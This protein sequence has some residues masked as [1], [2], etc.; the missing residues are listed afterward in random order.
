MTPPFFGVKA[1]TDIPCTEILDLIDKEI[2]F[3]SR[4]QFRRG[5][6]SSEWEK[7]REEVCLPIFN[8][9]AE[10]CLDKG[11]LETKALYGYFEDRKEG[12]LIFVSPS[13][14]SKTKKVQCFE[15]PRQKEEPHL[16]VADFFPDGFITMQL[17]TIGDRI[18]KEGSR[19]F[20]E[21]KYSDA[22]YLKGI[23]AEAAEAAA[24][25]TETF[26]KKELNV[27]I[28][29]GCRISFGYPAAPNLMDQKKLYMLLDGS[30]IGV[31]I[32]Q[33]Y[34]LVPE[35]STSAVVC[36]SEHSKIFRP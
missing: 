23:A 9:I 31:Q 15:F 10:M 16:C 8:H 4:W 12:N 35:Y 32:T 34:H 21:K 36:V 1:I 11:L 28:E 14:G 25:F 22:F 27:P 26:I 19:L 20:G 2:L 33:T 17:V 6:S 18:V 7:F 29:Q 5:K 13:V 24:K 30:K 3:S